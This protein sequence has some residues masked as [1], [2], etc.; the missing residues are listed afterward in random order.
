MM[1]HRLLA[2]GVACLVGAGGCGPDSNA[3]LSPESDTESQLKL[4]DRGGAA[5]DVIVILEESF[6]P[7]GHAANRA[8]AD[9]IGR[10]LGLSPKLTYG[11]AAFGFSATIPEARLNGLQRNP[12]VK[13]VEL[14]QIA[15]IPRPVTQAPKFCNNPANADHPAC[16][17]DSGGEDPVA[18][19]QTTPWGIERV[20][21][22]LPFAGS[23][24]AWIID[25]GIDFNH[26]DL[27]VDEA[28]SKNFVTRG[29]N[30]AKD[31]HGHG[32][33]VAGTVAAI[34]NSIDV[35]GVAPGA[36]VVA[37][38][39]LDNGGS[40]AYSWVIAGV[41]Y[42]AG[43][44]GPGDVANM[45]LSGP[46]S[47]ALDDAVVAASAKVKFALAA[48]NSSDDA[49]NHSPARA[50][51]LDIYTVSAMGQDN[52]L[53][54]FSNF[55]SA[56]DFAAPGV[57]VLSTKKGGGTTTLNGTSMAAPHV[58]G[59]LLLG[60]LGNDGKICGDRDPSPDPIAH[61]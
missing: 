46:V 19:T 5:V 15:S 30:S 52:C 40:G 32:T 44:A 35:V 59:L 2:L 6:A 29:K 26:A 37:V 22:G 61:R 4:R 36:T 56:V 13:Y 8:A 25:T 57:G 50:N 9:R 27:N 10:G 48:G 43:N 45:S 41:D 34:D 38:R 28:R 42:V 12:Q 3:P 23:E 20:G 55:G 49:N 31:G 14:D 1:K 24:T 39:V 51:G 54:S 16:A 7:G 17:P 58:A 47:Q 60:N 11:T 21:G 53:A 33:H 18:G